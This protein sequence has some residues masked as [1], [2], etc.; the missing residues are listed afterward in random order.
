[1]TT[2]NL[3]TKIIKINNPG[4]SRDEIRQA[5]DIIRSG[6]LVV[7][8]TETVYGL[9]GNATDPTA[10]AKIYAAK[11]RP[12]DNPLIIHIAD[13][14]DAEIYAHTNE[15]YYALA[16]TFM[17]GPLTVILPKKTIIPH[18]VTG[19]LETVAIR[20]PSHPTARALIAAAGVPIAAPSTNLSGKPSPTTVKHVIQD[21]N[22]R[23]DLIIDGGECDI[24]VEST[25]VSLSGGKATLLRPGA[26]TYEDL[27]TVCESVEISDAA[28][29]L[30]KMNERPL[31]PGMMYRHYAPSCP[32]ILLDGTTDAFVDFINRQRMKQ[33]LAVICS[34]DEARALRCGNIVL[35]GGEDDLSTQA[36]RLF[37][38]LREADELHCD[39]IYARL[40]SKEGLGLALYNRLI[41]AASNTV[42]KI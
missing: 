18:E 6:G 37:S 42:L 35:T 22:G 30:L 4:L 12:S 2:Q 17:P 11:G 25:I 39:V 24:G 36:H 38:A 13:P 34:P 29:G 41:R 26:V 31:A 40:P 20:C 7:F 16:R 32:L 27:I 10:A 1:M 19:G 15:Y 33:N 21:M 23:V 9:G 28:A 5:A 8:P 3:N 14:A